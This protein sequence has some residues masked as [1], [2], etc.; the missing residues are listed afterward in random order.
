MKKAF[1]IEY[2]LKESGVVTL[3]KCQSAEQREK[4]IEKLQKLGYN[5][6]KK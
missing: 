1:L 5:P 2:K 6:R 3:H 4:E